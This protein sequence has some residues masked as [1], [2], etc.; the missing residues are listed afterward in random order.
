[1]CSCPL[2]LL[3]SFEKR[4]VTAWHFEFHFKNVHLPP[5][6]FDPI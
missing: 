5:A 3:I 6:A 1:M 4:A 2:G